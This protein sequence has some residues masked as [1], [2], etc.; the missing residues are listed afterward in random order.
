MARRL[1]PS[2]RD[3]RDEQPTEPPVVPLSENVDPT[4]PKSAS[5]ARMRRHTLCDATN[6][7]VK[8][9]HQENEWLN[10]ELER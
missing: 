8:A 10:Q 6:G 3:I 4:A 5:K 7:K 9:L 1:W 2:I